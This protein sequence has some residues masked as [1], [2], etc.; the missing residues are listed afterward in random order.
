MNIVLPRNS[1]KRR[2][3]PLQSRSATSYATDPHSG[4]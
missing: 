1:E 3:I 2:Q 4:K